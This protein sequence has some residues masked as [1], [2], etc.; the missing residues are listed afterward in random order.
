[1]IKKNDNSLINLS[2]ERGKKEV[3]LY[4]LC[5]FYVRSIYALHTLDTESVGGVLWENS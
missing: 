1:M 2:C 4:V 3:T 5:T